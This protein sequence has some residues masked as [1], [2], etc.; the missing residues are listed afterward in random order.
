MSI[1]EKINEFKKKASRVRDITDAISQGTNGIRGLITNEIANS[2][3][4]GRGAANIER[5]KANLDKGVAS[6]SRYVVYITPP[7][8]LTGENTSYLMFR[9][10]NTELPGQTINVFNHQPMGFGTPRQMPTSYTLPPNLGITFLGSANYREWK[11]FSTWLDGIVKKPRE[12]AENV[13]GTHF[14]RFYSDYTCQICVVGYNELGDPVYECYFN[15]A[16]PI[17][18]NPINFAWATTDTTLTFPVQFA[19]KNWYDAGVRKDFE[20]KFPNFLSGIDSRIGAQITGALETGLRAFGIQ[21]PLPQ[22]VRDSINVIT[23][24]G[25][26]DFS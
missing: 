4:I 3:R 12:G 23:G 2:V 22:D 16:Y 11:F 18:V 7:K 25:L 17:Q 19:Y 26:L 20:S 24:G 21:D 1:L 14:V 15:D 6:V 10:E 9:T 8:M 13:N 5:M